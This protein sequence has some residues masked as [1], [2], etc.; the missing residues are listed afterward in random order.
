MWGYQAPPYLL[1]QRYKTEQAFTSD[2]DSLTRLVARREY[3]IMSVPFYHTPEGKSEVFMPVWLITPTG[4]RVLLQNTVMSMTTKKTLVETK[5]VNRAGSVVEETGED[6]WDINIKG[7]LV[8][9]DR[10]YP[11]SEVAELNELMEMGG[12]LGI[13]NARTSLVLTK[14]EKVI[15]RSL[16]L[17]ELRGMKNIQPFELNCMSD[18]DFK[19]EIE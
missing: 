16:K 9:K 15:L 19:L 3:N 18:I 6:N 11:D 5:M 8:S 10:D 4:K 1:L 17:P 14:G 7:I 13:Q 12:S 2:T